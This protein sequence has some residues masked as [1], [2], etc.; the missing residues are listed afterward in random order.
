MHIKTLG[1]DVFYS[2]E[3]SLMDG[4]MCTDLAS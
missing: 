3:L 2:F 4:D 1:L